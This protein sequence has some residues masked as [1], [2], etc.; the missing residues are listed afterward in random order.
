MKKIAVRKAGTIR[1]TSVASPLYDSTC[2]GGGG[3]GFP[4]PQPL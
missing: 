1:L 2:G 3:G 4:H